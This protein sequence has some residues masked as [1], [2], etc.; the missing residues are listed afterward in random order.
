MR[1]GLRRVLH[2]VRHGCDSECIGALRVMRRKQNRQREATGRNND[3]SHD[4]RRA[5]A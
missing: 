5:Q 1:H 4:A 2:N 3:A